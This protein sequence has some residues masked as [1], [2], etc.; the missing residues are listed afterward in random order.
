MGRGRVKSRRTILAAACAA[1][2]GT[3]LAPAA[4]ADTYPSRPIHIVVPFPPGGLNDNV[5]RIVQPYLQDKLGQTVIVENKPGASGMI[6][7]A[8]VAKAEPD[9]YTLLVVASSH[10]VAPATNAHMSF[11]TEHDLTAVSLLMR[12][13]LLFVERSSL[14]AKTLKDFVALAKKDPGKLTYATPGTDSQSHFVTELFAERASIK[15]L[16]VPYR[17]GAPAVLS[18]ISGQ[19]DLA[20]LSTQLS[21]PQIKAG[22]LRPLASGGSER[23]AQFPDVPTLKEAGYPDVQAL[24]WVGMLAPA[25]TPKEIVDKL[26]ATLHEVLALAV[27]KQKF[28]AQGISAT[29]STPDEFQH[30]IASEIAQWKAVAKSAGIKPH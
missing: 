25:K 29:S 22:K 17:G 5:V 27:V 30:L 3:C 19:T 14:P 9:G 15:L 1:I 2:L 24:Q 21:A 26:N 12:D 8:S 28:A 16:Q 10:T 6:G 13:P 11:D 7:T 20:V 23:L 18:L 4:Q